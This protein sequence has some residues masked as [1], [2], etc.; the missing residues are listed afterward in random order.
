ATAGL[1]R[2]EVVR[3][4][5]TALGAGGGL[6]CALGQ[7]EAAPRL[8]EEAIMRALV[9]LPPVMKAIASL[10][11]AFDSS[12]EESRYAF[13]AAVGLCVGAAPAA[14]AAGTDPMKCASARERVASALERME[15]AAQAWW[16]VEG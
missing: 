6:S 16:E 3:L 7:G 5:A 4:R 2:M 13:A 10:P 12:V 9:D 15:A 11:K 8:R 14:A 1:T